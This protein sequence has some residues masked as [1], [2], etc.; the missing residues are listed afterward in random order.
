MLFLPSQDSGVQRISDALLSEQ[1][2][3]TLNVR[4]QK[5]ILFT[6][7]ITAITA[8]ISLKVKVI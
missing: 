1:K 4:L 2:N 3:K 6:I 8:I 5:D 7:N